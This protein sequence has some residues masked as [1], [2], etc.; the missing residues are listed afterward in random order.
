M[1]RFLAMLQKD[2]VLGVKDIFVLME[3]GFAVFMVALLVLVVPEEI[4]TETTAFIYDQTGMI[5]RVAETVDVEETDALG[6][7]IV[8]S[9]E[10]VVQGMADNRSAVG[11]II[12]VT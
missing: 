2:M 1:K 4:D 5:E 9:R 6:D 12:G 7:F 11:V 10:A 8:D 3:I